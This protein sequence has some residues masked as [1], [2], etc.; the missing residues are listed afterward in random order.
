MCAPLEKAGRETTRPETRKPFGS[1]SEAP[2]FGEERTLTE[3]SRATFGLW[4]VAAA[5]FFFFFWLLCA[6]LAVFSLELENT[7]AMGSIRGN[8]LLRLDLFLQ[9]GEI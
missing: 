1:I 7:C 4:V 8:A 6:K 3:I 9:K 5:F 2:T